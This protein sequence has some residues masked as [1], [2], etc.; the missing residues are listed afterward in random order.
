[1]NT[2]LDQL[3]AQI[4]ELQGRVLFQDDTLEALDKIVGEQDSLLS[5]QQQ[6]LQLLAEK[7]KLLEGRLDD[8][9]VTI[10][11]ERPPHY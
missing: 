11:D 1:M 6:Q 5:R 9:P 7:I 10:T 4:E 8:S 3:Q 2:E